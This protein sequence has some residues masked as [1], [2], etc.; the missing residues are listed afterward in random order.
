LGWADLGA[1]YINILR[2]NQKLMDGKWD[3]IRRFENRVVLL[4]WIKIFA[5]KLLREK[6]LILNAVDFFRSPSIPTGPV[7]GPR[8][9]SEPAPAGHEKFRLKGLG[10]FVI[11]TIRARRP[12]FARPLKRIIVHFLAGISHSPRDAINLRGGEWSKSRLEPVRMLQWAA[13]AATLGAVH[14]IRVQV[15]HAFGS[16]FED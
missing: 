2:L 8:Q 16:S 10:V 14:Q 3:P 11:R 6:N 15:E 4:V 12:V 1:I 13:P 7:H 9:I 5:H